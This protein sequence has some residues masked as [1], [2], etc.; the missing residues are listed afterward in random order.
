MSALIIFSVPFRA[1]GLPQ[2]LYTP[3]RQAAGINLWPFYEY[4]NRNFQLFY[5]DSRLLSYPLSVLDI[6]S[7]IYDTVRTN[8]WRIMCVLKLSCFGCA[9]DSVVQDHYQDLGRQSFLVD[10]ELPKRS[11]KLHVLNHSENVYEELGSQSQCKLWFHIQCQAVRVRKPFMLDCVLLKIK[12]KQ[13]FHR[14]VSI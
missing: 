8:C 1:Y 4:S 14:L 5:S 3:I 7:L 9:G 2:Q 6:C 10:S 13:T 11:R 12:A